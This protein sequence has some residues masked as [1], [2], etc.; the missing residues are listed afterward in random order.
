MNAGNWIEL[1]A[2]I[3]TLLG[4]GAVGVNRVTRV[5]IA[6]EQFGKALETLG[7]AMAVTNTTMQAHE[8]RIAHVEGQ[9]LHQ[10]MTVTVPVIPVAP[11]VQPPPS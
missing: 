4:G 6:I 1:A 2:L 3:V 8:S 5:A 9:L 11:A 7:T 10:P